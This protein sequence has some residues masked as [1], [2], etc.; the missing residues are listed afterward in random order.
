MDFLRRTEALIGKGAVNI[1]KKSKVAV[2]GVGGVGG[3]ALE[4][5]VRSGVGEFLIVDKDIVDITNLN[6]QIIAT[7]ET[8]DRPKVDVAKERAISIN[9]HVTIDARLWEINKE[10]IPRLGLENYDYV[11]DAIDDLRAK[12]EL[13]TYCKS[14]DIE[15][16]SAMGAGRKLDP[17]RFKV[18]DIHKTKVDPI[19]RKLRYV[20]RE[21]NIKNL[22]VVY[23]DEEPIDLDKTVVSSI[24]FM[25]STM[26]LVMASEVIKDLIKSQK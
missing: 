16:I 26:G 18:E 9:P 12:T 15:I 3:F 21:R 23:S 17:T 19:A 11:V 22:K 20:M 7:M 2:I 5:L 24:A 8:I 1:L 14:N 25:P 13:I 6:R 10:N 4:A